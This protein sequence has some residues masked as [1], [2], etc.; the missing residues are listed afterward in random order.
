V[1]WVTVEDP[2][3]A[4]STS[5]VPLPTAYAS[6]DPNQQTGVTLTGAQVAYVD[7]DNLGGYDDARRYGPALR[8]VYTNFQ[9]T[10]HRAHGVSSP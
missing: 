1:Y 4:A 5:L 2:A 3:G 9:T 10:D 8:W 7:Y 6:D